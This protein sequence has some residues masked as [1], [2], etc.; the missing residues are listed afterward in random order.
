MT[1]NETEVRTHNLK[2]MALLWCSKAVNKE[3]ASLLGHHTT[4][5]TSVE[6]S[7]DL[8]SSPLRDLKDVIRV[9]SPSR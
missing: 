8:L 2:V 7:R 9:C 3:T 1:G 5:K 6:V 4:G